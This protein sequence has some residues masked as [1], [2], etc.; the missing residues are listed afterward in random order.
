M[1]ASNAFRSNLMQQLA[2]AALKSQRPPL[3]LT[4]W[5]Q[6]ALDDNKEDASS[7]AS[8]NASSLRIGM[9][10]S[11][12]SSSKNLAAPATPTRTRQSSATS[13]LHRLSSPSS[14]AVSSAISSPFPINRQMHSA[15]ENDEIDDLAKDF[16][17]FLQTRRT[18][19]HILPRQVRNR[20][21]S[22][23]NDALE[24]AVACAIQ[25]PNHKRTE[26]VT[27]KRMVAPSDKTHRL[28]DI[29]YNTHLRKKL[30]S[31]RPNA[32]EAERSAIHSNVEKKR[33]KWDQM[34]AFLVTLV[35]STHSL[36]GIGLPVAAD[37]YQPLDY[38]PPISERELED[39]ATACASVQNVLLSLHAEHIATKWV[40]GA[41]VQTPA[42]RE[43]VNA[44]AHERVVALIMVGEA[45]DSK[46]L[47]QRRRMRRAFH[48]DVLV[49][50]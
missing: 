45:D 35:N 37:P 15:S 31:L 32:S 42:F 40:T 5:I 48:G 27:F 6:N 39:Y 49:D 8:L 10:S 2:S 11:I 36:V 47:H 23:W 34:P 20:D 41:V 28:A 26:P 38:S 7:D 46:K 17:D 30:S 22:F 43:L 50:L 33:E 16:Q 14:A 29:A 44:K 3:A 9:L 12:G 4:G 24:R 25:A 13:N 21:A 19:T 18:G 1:N